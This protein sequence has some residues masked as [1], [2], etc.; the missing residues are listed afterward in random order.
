MGLITHAPY[1][2]QDRLDKHALEYATQRAA[3]AEA[4]IVQMD[5]RPLP[6]VS[7]RHAFDASPIGSVRSCGRLACA[8]VVCCLVMHWLL[9]A[10]HRVIP[11]SN[12]A[13]GEAAA[14]SGGTGAQG[15]G[16]VQGEDQGT[17]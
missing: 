12:V 13:G 3:E 15:A 1:S 11:R 16:Q 6:A 5:V 2:L 8:G 9:P 14:G 7:N 10:P 17:H 4:A